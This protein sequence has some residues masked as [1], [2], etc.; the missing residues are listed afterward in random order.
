MD[1]KDKIVFVS[2]GGSGI[3][4]GIASAFVKE[5]C[6]VFITGRTE[7]TL[8]K[9][10]ESVS[11]PGTIHYK[12]CDVAN[13]DDVKDAFEF[14]KSQK[15]APDIL[16]NSAGINVPKRLFK[17]ADPADWDKVMGVNAT[18][19]YNCTHYAL[20][21][22][23]EKREGFIVNINSV[24]GIHTLKLGG[25]QYC[26]SKYAAAS[27][28]TFTNLEEA[29]NG[30]RVTNIYPGETN[31]PILEKRAVVPPPEKREQ[32]VQPEDIAACVITI[33]KLPGRAVVTDLV[34]TPPYLILS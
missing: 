32:M 9:A 14:V 23:R 20:P 11:G 15:G 16:V 19:T 21:G 26:A 25:L 3:G 10:V 24:S 13:R 18:G 2:G 12:T 5:G 27:V 30:I 34:I 8:K 28:G 7:D 29:E 6:H 31:T 22:M 4:F 17:D 1:L 33:A